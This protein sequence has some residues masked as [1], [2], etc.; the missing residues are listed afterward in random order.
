M[1]GLEFYVFN[2]ELWCKRSDGTNEVVDETKTELVGFILSKIRE[3]YPEA[4]KT[5]EEI[6]SKS[7][8]NISYYQFLIVRRFCKCNFCRLDTTS[9]DVEDVDNEGKFN[10]EKVECPMRGECHYEGIVCTPKF[11][12]NLS[13]AENRVMRLYY[14]GRD[15]TEIS[16]ELFISPETV[17]N[18][19][20]SAYL[21]LGVH[22]K[23]EFVRYAQA[24][25]LFTN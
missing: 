17:K 13:P 20:K 9:Y 6:Y 14:L 12:S 3:C 22:E 4:Y 24:H 25:H 16:S 1:G 7:A 10:F 11:N 15:K 8:K 18:H 21:K 5:L 2:S 19:I 23:S